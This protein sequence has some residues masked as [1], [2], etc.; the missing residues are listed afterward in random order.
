M[1]LEAAGG[2][3]WIGSAVLRRC[4]SSGK[5]DAEQAFQ[6]ALTLREKLLGT[7]DPDVAVTLSDLAV[8]YQSEGLPAKSE[9]LFQRSLQIS[10]RILGYQHPRLAKVLNNLGVLYASEL[11][12]TRAEAA[13][14]R[15]LSIDEKALPPE[16]PDVILRP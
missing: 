6:K 11:Q 9:P 4:R 3:C 10:E 15:A 13:F 7:G 16:H 1:S 8:L 2:L 5:Q 14:R 12:F